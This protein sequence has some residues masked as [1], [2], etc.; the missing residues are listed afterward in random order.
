MLYDNDLYDVRTQPGRDGICYYNVNQFFMTYDQL[1]SKNKRMFAKFKRTYEAGW[2]GL[3]K[4]VDPLTGLPTAVDNEDLWS[5]RSGWRIVPATFGQ[6]A[7]SSLKK[8]VKA[9]CCWDTHKVQN[10]IM[11]NMMEEFRED[12]L[13]VNT[14]IRFN[15][16]IKEYNKDKEEM[17]QQWGGPDLLSK[18]EEWWR[19]VGQFTLEYLRRRWIFRVQDTWV[20]NRPMP[21]YDGGFCPE[22][23]CPRFDM[24]GI[25]VV[26]FERTSAACPADER[27]AAG[28]C[29]EERRQLLYGK[30]YERRHRILSADPPLRPSDPEDGRVERPRKLIIAKYS[31]AEEK[32]EIRRVPRDQ[33]FGT[34]VGL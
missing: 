17:W 18:N 26:D 9:A 29:V 8:G 28:N 31:D 2:E 27:D 19:D 25:V 14:L 15:D 23:T 24:G 34:G 16:W 13:A 33:F 20:F 21:C 11:G 3:P 4:K 7:A 6:W 32:P 12:Y 22:G 10:F 30:E 1:E 5:G